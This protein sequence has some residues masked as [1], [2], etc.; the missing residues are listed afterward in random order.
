M[1]LPKL[2]TPKY[3]V[4]IPSTKETIEYRPFL[5]KEEKVLL[6]AQ[7]SNDQKQIIKAMKDIISACTFE[8]ANVNRLT[9]YDVEY[10]F[11]QLRA[12]SVGET[13]K[14]KVKCEE[15]DHLTT[16]T[17]PLND[18]KIT[19]P[20]KKVDSTLQLNEDIGI[21]LRPFSI[22]DLSK[23]EAGTSANELTSTIALC[24]DTIF[25]KENVYDSKDS[26]KKELEE[27]VDSLHHQHIEKIQEFML[28]QPKICY[29]VEWTCSECG[30]KN[31]KVLEG[32]QSFFT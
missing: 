27:F 29:T 4:E 24:I 17:I 11:L 18:I 16:I 26:S 22:D 10:L 8:K 7:E 13:V 23:V 25:D 6:I 2:E 14:V 30:H 3:S 9:T 31:T 1:A 15:C 32:L 28:N 20:E 21:T 5:V 12:K 19:E